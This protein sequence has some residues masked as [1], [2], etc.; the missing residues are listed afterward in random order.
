MRDTLRPSC[1]AMENPPAAFAEGTV[2]AGGDGVRVAGTAAATGGADT[3]GRVDAGNGSGVISGRSGTT[4]AARAVTPN[5]DTMLNGRA[6]SGGGGIAAVR[7]AVRSV[8]I[9]MRNGLYNVKTLC[10]STS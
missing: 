1:R 4:S 2:G 3:T 8:S 10:F 9:T 6:L 7:A 5:I